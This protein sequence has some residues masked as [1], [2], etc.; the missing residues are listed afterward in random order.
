MASGAFRLAMPWAW[1]G[2]PATNSSASCTSPG[3]SA[4][5]VPSFTSPASP[6]PV[7]IAFAI[8]SVLPNIDS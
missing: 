5:T 7:A 6:K 3:D 4:S 8:I 2:P 1:V